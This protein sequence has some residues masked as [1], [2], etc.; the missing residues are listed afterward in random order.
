[1]VLSMTETE[2]KEAGE[3]RGGEMGFSWAEAMT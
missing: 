3:K 1:M 2:A